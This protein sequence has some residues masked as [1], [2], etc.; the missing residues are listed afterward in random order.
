M[1]VAY[2]NEYLAV[3]EPL[4][5][6]VED[7]G[8]HRPWELNLEVRSWLFMLTVKHFKMKLQF[9]DLKVCRDILN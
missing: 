6:P 2:Y 3:W 8:T 7:G 4:V 5:E 9:Q 1:E